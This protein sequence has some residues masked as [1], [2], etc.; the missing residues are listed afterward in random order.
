MNWYASSS[1]SCDMTRFLHSF[2]HLESVW[3]F[4][5]FSHCTVLT[6]DN[7]PL[8]G[9]KRAWPTSHYKVTKKAI[10]QLST[11]TKTQ[12]DQKPSGVSNLIHV[13]HY[14]ILNHPVS[15]SQATVIAV[16]LRVLLIKNG[17]YSH[18]CKSSDCTCG[19]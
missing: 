2:Q 3:C 9:W 1:W 13:S 17:K 5:L 14:T 19:R 6:D 11:A 4:R 10:Q 18:W 8:E 7:I 16:W 15:Y 12:G